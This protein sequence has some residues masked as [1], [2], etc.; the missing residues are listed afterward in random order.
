[1]ALLACWRKSNLVPTELE[2]IFFGFQFESGLSAL[3]S[4]ATL[5]SVGIH[6]CCHSCP[7]CSGVKTVPFACS[8][9]ATIMGNLDHAVL[10]AASLF[11]SDQS[12]SDLRTASAF[13]WSMFLLPSTAA[14]AV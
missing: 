5:R 1:M 11:E 13:H 2:N 3:M 7:G 9:Y 12:R 8:L 10:F 14:V 4:R 6:A